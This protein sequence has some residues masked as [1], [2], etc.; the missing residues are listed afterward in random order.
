MMAA[1]SIV[2]TGNMLLSLWCYD[3]KWDED[4]K[5][6]ALTVIAY[7]IALALICLKTMDPDFYFLVF[8]GNGQDKNH[9]KFFNHKGMYQRDL[10]IKA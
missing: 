8:L 4:V 2:F 7:A 6:P 9:F 10:V 1:L 3:K 5:S